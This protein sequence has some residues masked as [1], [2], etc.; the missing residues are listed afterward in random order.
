VTVKTGS[1]AP[2]L[3]VVP[4]SKRKDLIGK[5]KKRQVLMNSKRAN[6]VGLIPIEPRQAFLPGGRC[7]HGR[8]LG[9]EKN[10]T[11]QGLYCMT[12]EPR[13]KSEKKGGKVSSITYNTLYV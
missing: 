5:R 3:F 7:C 6:T 9:K 12:S 4:E 11:K 1:N 10:T 13:V 8:P 2:V